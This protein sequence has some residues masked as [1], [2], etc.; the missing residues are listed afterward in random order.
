[1]R[2]TGNLTL[3][4]TLLVCATASPALDAPAYA[5]LHSVS[6]PAQ[7]PSGRS[8][9]Y[10]V[11]YI[12]LQSNKL[13]EQIR[14]QPT[15]GGEAR[16]LGEG[17]APQWSADER[18]LAYCRGGYPCGQ[19]VIVEV[20]TGQE[21]VFAPPEQSF[22]ALHWMNQRAALGVLVTPAT[23]Q[24]THLAIL[25][26]EGVIQKDLPGFDG[27]RDY[28]FS[29]DDRELSVTL[30]Q[31]IELR[32]IDTP[33]KREIAKGPSRRSVALYSR[34]G[35]RLLYF[36]NEGTLGTPMRPVVLDLATMKATKLGQAF[37][38]WLL[39]YP[40]QW[41]EWSADGR[42]IL[43]GVPEHQ[44]FRLYR[45]D[46]RSGHTT[47]I[48]PP[49]VAPFWI[50]LDR[51]QRTMMFSL[52]TSD[53][54]PEVHATPLAK[55]AP[56]AVTHENPKPYDFAKATPL[57]WKSRDGTPIEGLFMRPR[58]APTGRVPLVV[59]M[60]G[61]FGTF[62][63]T[64]SGREVADDGALFPMSQQLFANEG[65]AVLMPNV[66][67][68]WGYGISFAQSIDGHFGIEPAED[69]LTG[70]AALDATGEIDADRVAIVGLW[71][72]G[73]RAALASAR[74]PRIR[75]VVVMNT[76]LDLSAWYPVDG[77]LGPERLKKMIGGDPWGSPELFASLS[78]FAQLGHVKAGTLCMVTE[79][80]PAWLAAQGEAYCNGLKTLGVDSRY[81]PPPPGGIEVVEAAGLSRPAARDERVDPEAVREKGDRANYVNGD[82]SHLIPAGGSGGYKLEITV[83]DLKLA[84][85]YR[86]ICARMSP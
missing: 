42:S 44:G 31:S 68:S 16:T 10:R 2:A 86:H 71:L 54:A 25:N 75:A 39:N 74:E 76:M 73:Y 26:P 47:A 50:T 41:F 23:G 59:L 46:L 17:R 19:V 8:V 36:E 30:P 78:P 55:F 58:S 1:M 63:T 43:F 51:E 21:H 33:D 34:D 12:D 6:H 18:W 4:L 11:R 29:P 60:E 85:E 3:A 27:A 84:A 5:T 45:L 37:Q 77:W 70:I 61:T 79:P 82:G 66:R 24:G 83:C 65:W 67:G 80:E 35:K 20:A 69:V 49:G 56:H 22:R 32:S 38:Y 48:D 72:D 15:S 62:D 53:T 13:I 14:V 81:L 57:T 28:D 40:P 52:S 9:A 64:F 7:S